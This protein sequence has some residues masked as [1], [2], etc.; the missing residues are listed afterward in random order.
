MKPFLVFVAL[1][2]LNVFLYL[3]AAVNQKVKE[4]KEMMKLQPDSVKIN[5]SDIFNRYN[6][7]YNFF[8]QQRLTNSSEFDIQSVYFKYNSAKGL[9]VPLKNAIWH[10]K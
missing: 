2:L 9:P 4:T 5:D 6:S 10:V 7:H 8:P 1:V 3:T